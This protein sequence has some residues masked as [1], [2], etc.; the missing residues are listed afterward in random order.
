MN[1]SIFRFAVVAFAFS[2]VVFA[3]PAK[4]IVMTFDIDGL[5][6]WDNIPDTYG[7]N[8]TSQD[9]G[10]FHYGL[11]NGFTPNVTVDYRTLQVGGGGGGTIVDHLKFWKTDYGDLVAI[12]APQEPRSTA[13]ISLVPQAGWGVCLNSFDLAGWLRADHLEQP[14]IVYDQNYNV[15]L[16]LSGLTV[17]G[18]SH[19]NVEP[20]LVYAGTLHIQ[21]GDN[22][23]VGIDNLN[24]DQVK[25]PEVS[26]T[27]G[28]LG[29]TLAAIRVLKARSRNR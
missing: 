10:A 7:D 15:L 17:S 2:M 24:F 26:S 25:V 28:L 27:L 11:G 23:N 18:S 29:L 19:T 8:V 13:E 6:C 16:D 12:A 20:N 1:R 5:N 14:L 3:S 21:Y 22:Y 4:A 9:M